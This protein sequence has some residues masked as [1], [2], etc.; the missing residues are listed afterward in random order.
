MSVIASAN[1][2]LHGQVVEAV[3]AGIER[4]RAPLV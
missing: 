2:E 4:L 1:A 3:T